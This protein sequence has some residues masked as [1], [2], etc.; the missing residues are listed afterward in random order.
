[1][2]NDHERR[3]LDEL[4]RQFTVEARGSCGPRPLRRQCRRRD[5]HGS[6]VRAVVVVV[7]WLAVFL[8]I[9]GATIAALALAAAAVLG[10]LVWRYWPQLRDDG[11]AAVP[12]QTDEEPTSG[13]S[14][15]RPGVDW[16][17]QHLKRISEGE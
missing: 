13:A 2:L 10:W 6:T 3:V 8:L 9:A 7:G 12:P 16:L 5:R 15:R 14:T 17:S 1:V 11:A 4:E